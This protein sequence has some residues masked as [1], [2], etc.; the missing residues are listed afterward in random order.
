[1]KKKKKRQQKRPP[2]AKPAL[3]AVDGVD[4]AAVLAEARVALGSRSRGGISRWDASGLFQELA[5]GEAEAG[6]PSART[7]LLLYAADLAFRL[8]WEIRPALAEGR[9]VVAA[10]Y[11]ATAVAFGRAAGLKAGWLKSLF[12]FAPRTRYRR[13]VHPRSARTA[14][15]EDGFVGFSCDRVTAGRTR[16]QIIEETAAQLR[17]LDR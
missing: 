11:V 17:R 9:T 12:L 13:F 1:V 5:V 8:R 16:R 2:A 15:V 4:A 3:I 6:L 14:A 10:P 7:L